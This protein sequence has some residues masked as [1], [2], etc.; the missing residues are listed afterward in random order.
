MDDLGG[1]AHIDPGSGHRLALHTSA[2]RLRTE[3]RGVFGQETI[4]RFLCGVYGDVAVRGDAPDDLLSLT[5]RYARRRLQALAR[6][7]GVGGDARPVVLYLCEHNAG[8]SLM[9]MGLTARLAGGRAVAWSA[10]SGPGDAANGAAV[11]AMGERGIDIS[12]E[13][14]SA[15]TDELVRAADVI[16]TMGCGDACPVFP[17]KRYVDWPLPDPRGWRAAAVRPLRDEIE[18]RVRAL[19]ADLGI[20]P[21]D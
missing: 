14:P 21:R 20:E 2:R 3:F 7:D 17:G 18:H 12:A 11:A 5:E 9:A 16:V 4:E 6:M 13:F 1:Y 19:L 8:R 15:W 10:G